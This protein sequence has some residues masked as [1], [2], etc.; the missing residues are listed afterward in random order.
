MLPALVA[1][2]I[3]VTLAT[4]V[5]AAAAAAQDGPAVTFAQ[6]IAPILAKHCATCHRPTGVAPFSLLTY[7]DARQRASLIVDVTKRR[8]M[9]PWK[10]EGMRGAFLDERALSDDDI[11]T[12]ERW[13]V[14]GALEGESASERAGGGSETVRPPEAADSDWQ[15]GVPD[16]VV[17]MAEPFVLPAGGGDVFRT[18][19]LPIPWNVPTYVRAIEFRPGNARVVHHVNMGVDRTRS[20]R[21][22][23]DAEAGPGYSGGMSNTA[24]YPPGHM[25]GWTPGQRPRPSPEDAQW[26]L[27]TGSDL[28]VQL[29][30]QPTGKPEPVQASVG[31][32][33]T[34]TPP[35]RTPIGLRLGS[36]TID[37][38]PGV[39]THSI[40][41]QFVLPVDAELL[42]VQPHAHNLARRIEAAAVLP[43]GSRRPLIT[44]GDWDFR[45]QDVYRYARP[46]LLPKGT[47]ISMTFT[48]DNSEANPRN[49]NRP[50]RRVVW[51]QNTSNEMGDLWLQLMVRNPAE[52]MLLNDAV[53]KKRRDEDIAAYTKLL[54]ESP[55]D[56]QLHGVLAMIYLQGQQPGLAAQ[57][58]RQSLLAD[59]VWAAGHYNLGVAL[60]SLGQLDAATRSF[61]EAVRLNPDYADAHNNLGVMYHVRGQ[62]PDA[63]VHYERAIALRPDNAEARSNLAQILVLQGQAAEAIAQFK[64][65]LELRPESPGPMAGQ[66]WAM[67]TAPGAPIDP[68]AALWFGERAVA[69]TGRRDAIALDAYAA[70]LAAVGRFEQAVATARQALDVAKTSGALTLVAQI[71]S[72][73]A[74][75]ERRQRFQITPVR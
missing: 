29:H 14:S 13:V 34:D 27:E 31:F 62:L 51:G 30:L 5:P 67:A 11:R 66:A 57:H 47:R 38:P 59:P 49:P 68:P 61:R 55:G 65:A 63:V 71:E 44:I 9:P 25:L 17:T 10:P 22:L 46:L 64:R 73:M 12:L 18:F 72:R 15:L 8:V 2:A 3:A 48:Y 52:L 40:R 54:E 6:H 35:T 1:A 20:S 7:E 50:A 60:S 19:V 42:A 28:V 45:W 26:R 43:D 37:I 23:D 21:H 41:D 70:A 56:A 58:F 24:G 74:A 4:A 39:A 53:E 69:L 36:Q 75:Y 16:L 33:F 32:Y